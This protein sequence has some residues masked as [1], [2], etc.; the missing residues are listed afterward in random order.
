MRVVGA[1]AGV[2]VEQLARDA[3]LVDLARILELDLQQAAFAA[4]VAERFP[5]RPGHLGERL[6]PPEGGDGLRLRR[7]ASTGAPLRAVSMPTRAR[8]PPPSPRAARQTSR[9]RDTPTT[10]S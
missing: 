5:L 7:A 8:P 3:G 4:A 6:A 2:P 1:A 9:R 10:P